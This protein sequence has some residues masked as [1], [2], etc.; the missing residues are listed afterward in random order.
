MSMNGL[1]GPG[2]CLLTVVRWLSLMLT[3]VREVRVLVNT[4]YTKLLQTCQMGQF[5]SHVIK[6]SRD[7][8]NTP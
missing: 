2:Q 3:G 5:I 7:F 8:V 4:V 6:G 1:H